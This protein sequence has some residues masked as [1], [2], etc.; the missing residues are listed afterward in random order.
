MDSEEVDGLAPR[1]NTR[2]RASTRSCRTVPRSAACSSTAKA[3]ARCSAG[4]MTR[5]RRM[6]STAAGVSATT[7]RCRRGSARRARRDARAA[8]TRSRSRGNTATR[9]GRSARGYTEVGEDFNPEVGFLSRRDYKKIEGR[10]VPACAPRGRA[11]L[12]D[13]AAH[14]LS[15]LLGLRGLPGNRLPAHGYA[16]GVA[17]EPRV[18][19]RS[20][21][22]AR[23]LEAAV[24][25]RAR[26]DDSTWHVRARGATARISRRSVAAVELPDFGRRSAAA[27]A[28]TV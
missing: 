19:H 15:R 11:V 25:H 27:S 22:H 24:R 23:G 13:P 2:S 4:P 12:R 14:H 6:G 18:S 17:I 8:T 10:D 3:T 9:T 28:A 7:A 26:R 20:E 16:L 5:I 21:P 1:T